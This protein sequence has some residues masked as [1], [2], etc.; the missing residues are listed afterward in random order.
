MH[1]KCAGIWIKAGLPSFTNLRIRPGDNLDL[2]TGVRPRGATNC[3]GVIKYYRERTANLKYD[4]LSRQPS[5]I[6]IILIQRGL[7]KESTIFMSFAGGPGIH[8][9]IAEKRENIG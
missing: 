6:C 5:A 7:T 1:P 8:G 4:R 3:R 2:V 9:I